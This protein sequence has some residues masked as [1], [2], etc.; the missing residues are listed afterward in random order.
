M[1]AFTSLGIENENC[2]IRIEDPSFLH[3]YISTL[4]EGDQIPLPLKYLF[5]ELLEYLLRIYRIIAIEGS[6]LLLLCHNAATADYLV[7]LACHVG[8]NDF[9]KLNGQLVSL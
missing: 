9:Y 4:L 6:H 3:S 1:F 5:N 7:Q 2:Y 8:Q